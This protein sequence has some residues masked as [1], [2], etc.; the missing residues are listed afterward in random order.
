M[1]DMH[2]LVFMM[3]SRVGSN[4]FILLTAMVIILYWEQEFTG[5]GPLWRDVAFGALSISGIIGAVAFKMF[6]KGMKDVRDTVKE[7]IRKRDEQHRKNQEILIRLIE[8]LKSG[9]HKDLSSGDV[10]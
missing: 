3:L 10:L 7:E 5:A 8:A 1:K 2:D 4:L 6:M 9:E